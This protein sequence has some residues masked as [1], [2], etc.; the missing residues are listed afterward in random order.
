MNKPALFA[1]IALAAAAA[2]ASAQEATYEYPQPA[3][4][5]TTRAAVQAELLQARQAGTLIVGE[6]ASQQWPASVSTLSRAE[7]NAAVL[8][9]KASGEL[10]AIHGENGTFDGKVVSQRAVTGVV[11]ASK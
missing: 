5:V 11:T 2:G 9:A 3:G 7:V 6:Y 1:A 8:A 4:S 10:P